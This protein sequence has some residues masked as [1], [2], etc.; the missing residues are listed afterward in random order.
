MFL[1]KCRAVERQLTS[2]YFHSRMAGMFDNFRRNPA[3]Q[4]EVK[5][6]VGAK[7]CEGILTDIAKELLFGRSVV[8]LE[9]AGQQNC[10][11]T[12]KAMGSN[13]CQSR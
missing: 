12:S 5:Y 1:K 13:S 10:I 7:G 4:I 8:L 3:H 6:V 2:T 11:R 9:L